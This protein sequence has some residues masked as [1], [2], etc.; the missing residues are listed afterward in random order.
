MAIGILKL[1][2][3]DIGL[4][5]TGIAGPDGGSEDKPV[6][7][8]YIGLADKNKCFSTKLD[9]PSRLSRTYIRHRAASTAL[10]TV[11]LLLLENKA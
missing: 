4:S 11:R 1:A 3:A 5:I 10:N 6:G 2:K 9:L 7:L 8:V